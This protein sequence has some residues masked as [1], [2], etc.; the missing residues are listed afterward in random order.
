[1]QDLFD[2]GLKVTFKPVSFP[3]DIT[4][5]VYNREGIEDEIRRFNEECAVQTLKECLRNREHVKELYG[6]TPRIT[7]ERLYQARRYLKA[8]TRN[9]YTIVEAAKIVKSMYSETAKNQKVIKRINE[10]ITYFQKVTP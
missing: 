4:I 9:A 6:A 7:S 5:T 1:Q 3:E 10:I 8:R 2:E